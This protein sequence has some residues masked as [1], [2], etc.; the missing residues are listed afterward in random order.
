MYPSEKIAVKR[1]RAISSKRKTLPLS[2]LFALL[3]SVIGI[4]AILAGA[5][6]LLYTT[7][8]QVQITD[9]ETENADLNGQVI[10]LS[11]RISTLNDKYQDLLTAHEKLAT[12]YQALKKIALVPPYISVAHRTMTITFTKIDQTTERWEVPFDTLESVLQRGAFVRNSI[13]HDN[14]MWIKLNNTNTG[15]SYRGIDMTKFVDASSFADVIPDLYVEAGSDDAFIREVW[16]IVTQLTV[17][18]TEIEDTPRYPLETLL[19]GGG[20][21]E[22]TAILFASMILAAPVDWDVELVYLDADNPTNPQEVNHV[23]VSIDTCSQKYLIETTEGEDMQ[24]YTEGVTGWF[25]KVP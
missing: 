5:A 16:H 22:D 11:N 13:Q 4:C 14:S 17:Y 25:F 1:T 7:N 10:D 8:F 19:A 6:A 20:D 9:L 18:S 12:D 3:V 15:E 2:N 24:P 21:C 23:V